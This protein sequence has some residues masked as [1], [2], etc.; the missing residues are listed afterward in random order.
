MRPWRLSVQLVLLPMV[1]VLLA[2]EPAIGDAWIAVT[3]NGTSVAQDLAAATPPALSVKGYDDSGIDVAIDAS[4]FALTPRKTK[5]GQFM[6]VTWTDA[7][8]AGEIGA[9]GIP[10]MRRVFE[11]PAD[12][13]PT[14]SI[15]ADAP[16]VIDAREIGY[17]FP[18]IPVQPP[19]P[20]LPGAIERAEFVRD[21]L[22]YAVDADLLGERAVVEELGI[23]RGQRL[24]LLEV[25]PVDHNPVAGTFTL[26]PRIDVR[27]DFVGERGPA[28]PHVPLATVQR[29]LLNPSLI[30]PG[31][32]GSG[33]YLIVV[34]S[35]Y[36]S[37]IASFAAAK[38]AQG[39]TVSTYVPPSAS[40][41]VIKSHIQ[42][43][44]GTADEPD[45]ILLVGDTNTIPKW[46]G[47]G[48][49]S[50]DTD[51]PYACMDGTSDWY[52]DIPLG[53]F[54]VRTTGQLQAIV[55]K[56]LYY[57]NG[58]LADPDYVK[59]AVFMASED[60]Y[61]VSEGTHNWVISNYMNPNDIVSDKLYCHTYNATTQQVRNS[62]NDGRFFGI[63]SGHGGTTVWADGPY[64]SQ[65]DVNGLLNTNM[66]PFVM[67]F[68]CVT[69][70]YALDECFVET[71]IRAANKGALTIYGSSVNS[72]WTEDDVLEK[73]LFDAI[74][75]LEDDVAS[76]VGPVWID[77][78]VRYRAQMGS[79]STTRRYHEMYNLM[80]DPSLRFPGACTD[81]G[82]VTLDRAKYGCESTAHI[83]VGDCG[84]NTD[85]GVV[86]YVTVAIDSDSE[87]GVEEVLLTES[88][89]ASAKFE[90][91]INLSATDSAGVLLVAESDT[92]TVTYVDADDGA[93]NTNVVVT[94]TA[95]IDCQP[96]NISN[97]Q[98]TNIEPRSA[99]VTF[100]ADEPVQGKVHYGSACTSLNK[101]AVGSGYSIFASVNLTGLDIGTTY[102]YAV[103]AADEA[104]NSASDDN[105]GDCYWFTTPDVP[106]YFTEQ[107]EG[108]FDLDGLSL[109]FTPS[110]GTTDFYTGC[111]EEI[112]ELP[113]DPTGGTSLSFTPS[114]DDGYATINLGSGATVS[115]YGTGYS[116]F[117][118]GTNGYITF[119]HGET[120][121][122][123]SLETHFSGVPRISALFDD[124]NPGAGGTVSWKQ[125]TDRAV[126]TWQNVPKYYDEGSNTFQIELFFNGTITISYLGISNTEGIA[127]LSAGVGMDPDFYES[128]LSAMGACVPPGDCD[129]DGDVDE[130]DYAVFV[131]CFTGPGGSAGPECACVTL[132]GDG[133]VDC[134][135]LNLFYQLWNGSG[136]PPTYGPC[137]AP[138]VVAIGGR[139]LAVT[140]APGSDPVA[141]LVTGDQS[142]PGVACV[143]LYVQADGSLDTTAVFRS[144]SGSD[145][146][147]TVNVYGE[148]I[149]PETVY[150][151]Q[152]NYGTL[153]DPSMSPAGSAA[154]MLW[155]DSQCN[156]IIN[157]T[158]VQWIVLAWEGTSYL[159][160]FEAMNI[161]PCDLDDEL[162][163]TDIQA[164]VLSFE[165]TEYRGAICSPP[166]Q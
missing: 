131:D 4:G 114:S 116:S 93:G 57:E 46:T 100:E 39:F 37:S 158:D 159:A 36:E 38:S 7:S 66:Y 154:T 49:G 90:G 25:R 21:D 31:A 162:N 78:L 27:I 19:I 139:Y 84:L 161:A 142:D 101:T 88:D 8:I 150:N 30:A 52:P 64:F 165:G 148:E 157:F 65:S 124:L 26:W 92:V 118:P 62:F 77:T 151:V 134:K 127:G 59:R 85:D 166:C 18:V 147:N 108:D 120:G 125:L 12:T 50:P 58:P 22:A 149:M 91:S 32:R 163:F 29:T 67:S 99:V 80:G 2:G 9:P 129:E 48:E 103:E 55:D 115:I 95:S 104:G 132:D 10:V 24:F 70:S 3:A 53:R 41:S 28:N 73:R 68:A 106:D 89:P 94:A 146:W 109:T 138:T 98:T 74:Y 141:L 72:Y 63:Y 140:P 51:L 47:G 122:S 113:T 96:P 17:P 160:P 102:A 123:E 128:D 15:N 82:T 143:S 156:E 86:E 44:W 153:A 126:V 105:G 81:A 119:V 40:S 164:A 69:G 136:D 144:P 135:D 110:G 35:A 75:D 83:T 45:Y 60:N 117:F 130:D 145:G 87:T 137:A 5:G 61:T 97:I 1:V 56:T 121:Y 71:W 76:E 107:F 43:L 6:E 42:S 20:K 16:V 11:A 133:D 14:L 112:D 33:N 23:V 111:A 152:G 54:P 13:V 34:A 155:G 79:G